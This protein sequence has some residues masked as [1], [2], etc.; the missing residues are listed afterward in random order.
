VR[1]EGDRDGG[2]GEEAAGEVLEVKLKV[3]VHVGDER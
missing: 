3:V 2:M 1:E